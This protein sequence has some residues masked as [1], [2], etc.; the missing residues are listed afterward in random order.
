MR[1][2]VFRVAATAVV[3]LMVASPGQLCSEQIDACFNPRS[4]RLRLLTATSPDCLNFELPISWNTQE[5]TPPVIDRTLTCDNVFDLTVGLTISDDDEVAFYAIQKQ[6]TD[7]ALNYVYSVEPGVQIVDYE[8]TIGVGS[9]EEWYLV[10]ASDVEGNV[11]KD[12]FSVP[13]D[14]CLTP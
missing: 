1:I 4:G 8:I 11:S 3:L 12:L 5:F 2:G 9:N 14:F 10:L 7:P 6:G 13:P